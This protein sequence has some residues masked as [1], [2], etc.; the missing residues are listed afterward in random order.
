[1]YIYV[2]D[3]A[4][5]ESAIFSARIA[6]ANCVCVCVWGGCYKS[7]QVKVNTLLLQKVCKRIYNGGI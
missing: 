2:T 5:Q 6:L 4:F 3:N 1:M 7:E